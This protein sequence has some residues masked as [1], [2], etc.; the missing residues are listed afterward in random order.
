MTR[1]LAVQYALMALVAASVLAFSLAA[2]A[3][4]EEQSENVKVVMRVLDSANAEVQAEMLELQQ[5]GITIPIGAEP[6]Y[7][8]ALTEYRAAK[9]ALDSGNANWAKFHAMR[10]MEMFKNVTDLLGKPGNEDQQIANT[11]AL[12]E[13]I[14]SVEK[15]AEYLQ[16]LAESNNATVSFADYD[17]AINAAKDARV[18]GNIEEASEQLALA[19]PSLEQIQNEIQAAADSKKEDRAKEYAQKMIT[20]LS[21]EIAEQEERNNLGDRKSLIQE[22]TTVVEELRFA[23]D[24]DE[25]ID[26]TDDSSELQTILDDYKVFISYSEVVKDELE[27]VDEPAVDSNTEGSDTG[28]GNEGSGDDPAKRLTDLADA[29]EERANIL[30]EQ[31]DNL[32]ADLLIQ[33]ALALIPSARQSIDEGSYDAA[34]EALS[35]AEIALNEAE[36]LM[37]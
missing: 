15:H 9:E 25:I 33:K 8:A 6:Y 1:T 18:R 36:E 29:L 12:D 10:A 34:E 16:T 7:D 24:F 21:A 4:A 31:S 35:A 5:R 22:L 3:M 23:M 37:G 26:L 28:S 20:L 17:S 14:V 11:D 19:R 30:L 27:S 32:A 13:N 2:P